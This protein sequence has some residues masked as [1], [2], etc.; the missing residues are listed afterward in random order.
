MSN[1]KKNGLC[2]NCIYLTISVLFHP[3][4]S[5]FFSLSPQEDA[6]KN[7]SVGFVV[8]RGFARISLTDSIV[9][10]SGSLPEQ[11]SY[12]MPKCSTRLF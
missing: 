11:Q 8:L 3:S 6:Y 4:P 7:G 1:A 9:L 5:S 10:R 2:G 12:P